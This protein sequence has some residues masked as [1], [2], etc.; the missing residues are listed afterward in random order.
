M[1]PEGARAGE[2]AAAAEHLELDLPGGEAQVGVDEQRAGEQTR[3][4][5]NLKA[6]ADPQHEAA[7]TG[8]R[9]HGLH[10][11]RE[12]RDR[13]RA[14][15]VAVGEAAW[16]DDRV[17][18]FEVAVGV[19]DQLGVAHAAGGVQRIDLI[20][21]SGKLQDPELHVASGAAV[22]VEQLDLIVL[23]ERVGEQ[24]LA[25]GLELRGVLDIELHEASDVDVAHAGEA[26]CRQRALDGHALRIEDPRLG[27]DQNTCS[28]ATAVRSSHAWKG[29]PVMRSYAST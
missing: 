13:P 23:D 7:V 26:E 20:A 14:Q 24:L 4:A 15:V 11:G 27:A 17:G 2:R 1:L 19:P 5:E 29:S 6:V 28:H 9:D 8:E 18:P 10:R 22:A 21:R 12:A 16:D 25:H 3:L